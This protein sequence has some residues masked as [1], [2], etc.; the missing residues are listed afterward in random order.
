MGLEEAGVAEPLMVPLWIE[1]LGCSSLG[2]SRM[3]DSLALRPLGRAEDSTLW[4]SERPDEGAGLSGYEE[5][6]FYLLFCMFLF[7]LFI[8]I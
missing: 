2:L 8:T 4:F 3:A 5:K 1:W 7:F 6:Y